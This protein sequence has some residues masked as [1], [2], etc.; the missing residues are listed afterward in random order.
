MVS[1]YIMTKYAYIY[2]EDVCKTVGLTL[3]VQRIIAE[4]ASTTERLIPIELRQVDQ[5]LKDTH[6]AVIVDYFAIFPQFVDWSSVSQ[7]LQYIGQCSHVALLCRDLHAWTFYDSKNFF[8]RR[9]YGYQNLVHMVKY[10]NVKYM[11][12]NYN[13]KEFRYIVSLTRCKPYL[14][15]W[16]VDTRI[17]R[18]MCSEK[19]YDI[20]VYGS[21]DIKH[22]PFRHRVKRII[23]NMDDVNKYILNYTT[24]DKFRETG[25]AEL[26]SSSWLTLATSSKYDY[27]V[28][29]YFEASAC[30]SV[31]VCDMP[32]YGKPIWNDNYIS[33]NDSMT[34]QEIR[35]TIYS[36][37]E[38]KS[39]LTEMAD[40]MKAVIHGSYGYQHYVEKLVTLMGKIINN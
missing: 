7:H 14:L 18:P 17:F 36:A 39:R 8:A 16:H 21:D 9:L 27:L 1:N 22:Y 15:V 3:K 20:F 31:L 24:K 23:A 40:N 33:I 26:L 5:T 38:N 10:L 28:Q 19:K 25:L 37:L 2:N 29:K 34:D 32:Y 4:Y 6:D 11:I 12:T 13:C 35:D 30:G